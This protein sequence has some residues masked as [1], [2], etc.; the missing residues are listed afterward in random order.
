MDNQYV[1][2]SNMGGKFIIGTDGT[3]EFDVMHA[4]MSRE[5]REAER[6]AREATSMR[7]DY[8]KARNDR[9]AKVRSDAAKANAAAAAKKRDIDYNKTRVKGTVRQLAKMFDNYTVSDSVAATLTDKTEI[10]MVLTIDGKSV[11]SWEYNLDGTR[12]K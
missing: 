4:S 12:L 6:R 3:S 2:H 8:V 5:A 10:G 11:A 7:S 1:V 9:A